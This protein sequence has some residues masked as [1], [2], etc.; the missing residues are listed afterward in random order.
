MDGDTAKGEDVTIGEVVTMDGDA[1]NGEDA[2]I[3]EDV[4]MDGDAAKGEDVA[5]GAWL[6][7]ELSFSY[8]SIGSVVP[9]S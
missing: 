7:V 8:L 5:I 6:K 1:A 4:T 2:P 3:S 9:S